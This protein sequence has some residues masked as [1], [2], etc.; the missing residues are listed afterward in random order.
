MIFFP[1]KITKA[2]IMNGNYL[3]TYNSYLIVKLTVSLYFNIV[4]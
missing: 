3:L 2:A 1:F 4:H